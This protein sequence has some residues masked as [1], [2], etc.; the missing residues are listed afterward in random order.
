MTSIKTLDIFPVGRIIQ[1]ESPLNLWAA[2]FESYTLAP[3]APETTRPKCLT[4]QD[5][6]S[7]LVDFLLTQELSKGFEWNIFLSSEVSVSGIGSL[8]IKDGV[9][10][11]PRLVPEYWSR[12]YFDNAY[13]NVAFE[14]TLAERIVEEPCVC[15]IGWGWD[16]YGHF[17]IEGLPRLLAAMEMLQG[18]APEFRLLLRQDTPDWLLDIVQSHLLIDKSRIVFFD[19]KTERVRLMRGVFPAQAKQRNAFHPC[20]RALTAR[21]LKNLPENS[22]NRAGKYFITRKLVPEKWN[23]ARHCSNEEELLAIAETYGYE[24]YAPETEPWRD[25]VAKFR[26][27]R[28]VAGIWG[29][30]LHTSI[31]AD[32]NLKIGFIGALNDVQFNISA[33]TG[34]SFSAFTA[35]L[36]ISGEFSVPVDSFRRFLDSL[37]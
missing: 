5:L 10:L 4:P 23:R 2:P 17:M 35:G 8:W 36:N 19:P 12:M 30:A 26:A 6:R 33:L 25:Q 18:S 29:S 9:I 16:V 32:E 14:Q 7:R 22:E 27:A 15:V 3:E 24:T 37:E 21:H 13:G 20:L 31:F 34:Q 1:R 28:I 11:D